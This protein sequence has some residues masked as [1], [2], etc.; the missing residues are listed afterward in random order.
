MPLTWLTF[1]YFTLFW[2]VVFISGLHTSPVLWDYSPDKQAWI[3]SLLFLPLL[4]EHLQVF[5]LLYTLRF[6]APGQLCALGLN[7]TSHP[8]F[9]WISANRTVKVCT[10]ERHTRPH[11]HVIREWKQ[12]HSGTHCCLIIGMLTQLAD[13]TAANGTQ[14]ATRG[15]AFCRRDR[16]TQKGFKDAT[17]DSSLNKQAA[18]HL[19]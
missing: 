17:S 10:I 7:L 2:D 3:T 16:E 12:S 9:S 18:D 1:L 13:A 5:S 14:R 4:L 11:I 15:G 19:S 8:F 6:I